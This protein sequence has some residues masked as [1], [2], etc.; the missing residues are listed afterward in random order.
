MKDQNFRNERADMANT[1]EPN[2]ATSHADA[3][4]LQGASYKAELEAE[5]VAAV[6]IV[7][8]LP[9]ISS[10]VGR[11]ALLSLPHQDISPQSH[12]LE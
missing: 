12:E 9:S 5:G 2:F 8:V 4:R 1:S 6:E 11:R 10:M 7:A 3:R